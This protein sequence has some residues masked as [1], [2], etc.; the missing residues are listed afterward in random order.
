MKFS[1][2]GLASMIFISQYAL[3]EV[4]S[5][6]DASPI[7]KK[8]QEDF[9]KDLNFSDK[10]DFIDAT[11]GLIASFPNGKIVDKAGKVV[12]DLKSYEFINNK[13]APPTVNPSLW[14]QEQLNNIA[15]L[16]KV[17]DGIYQV[18]GLDLS[19]MTIIEGQ[20]GLIIVDPLISSETAAAALKL[21]HDNISKNL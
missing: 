11:R 2:I 17:S 9:K 7:T 14:R 10:Q 18:R 8:Y 4:N 19:N 6:K 12:W 16:F 13:E 15:G 1:K 20:S 5:P 21:Y 3:A